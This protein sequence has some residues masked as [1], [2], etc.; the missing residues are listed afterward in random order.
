MISEV[1]SI[2]SKR[3]A[4][5]PI[6]YLGCPIF[7]GRKKKQIF[8]PLVENV[9]HKLDGKKHKLLS[10]EGRL[11]LVHHLLSSIPIH[12]LSVMN[13]PKGT[14]QDL[15]CYF[16]S[17]FWGESDWGSRRNWRKWSRICLPT[18]EAGLGVR[19]FNTIFESFSLKMWLNFYTSNSFGLLLCIFC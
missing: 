19:Y 6:H 16:A 10:P 3:K 14:I 1:E 11:I 17:F 4:S 8:E 5:L 18:Q 2:S 13:P 7:V 15:E 9:R 12:V